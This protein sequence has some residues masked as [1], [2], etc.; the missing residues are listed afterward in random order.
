MRLLIMFDAPRFQ[1]F[2]YHGMRFRFCIFA[3]TKNFDLPQFV[4]A[5]M[6]RDVPLP[7]LDPRPDREP[8][9]SIFHCPYYYRAFMRGLWIMR[10]FSKNP[11]SFGDKS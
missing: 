3:G 4:A 6:D 2:I 5:R 8:H 10:Y 1:P 9:A 7:S 11:L